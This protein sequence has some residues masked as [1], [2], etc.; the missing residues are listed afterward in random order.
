MLSV[1]ICLARRSIGSPL[2]RRRAFRCVVDKH[3]VQPESVIARLIA[4][5][6]YHRHAPPGS[7]LGLQAAD[8]VKQSTSYVARLTSMARKSIFLKSSGSAF[9]V[10]SASPLIS[11]SHVSESEALI[12]AL[13]L[14]H[15]ISR[16]RRRSAF[17]ALPFNT[18]NKPLSRCPDWCTMT[19]LGLLSGRVS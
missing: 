19:V 6:R 8:E 5:D 9:T 11:T 1:L 18:P 14:L 13:Y 16:E 15:R 2:D 17:S 10:K 4:A 7:N 3:P 12:G